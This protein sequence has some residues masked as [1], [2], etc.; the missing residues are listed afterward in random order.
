VKAPMR[1]S[2]LKAFSSELSQFGF[3]K[4]IH[5]G[6]GP[7]SAGARPNHRRES[8]KFGWGRHYFTASDSRLGALIV[9]RSG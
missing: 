8:L 1:A 9:G 7:E 4:V 2:V 3:Q 6:G 5:V